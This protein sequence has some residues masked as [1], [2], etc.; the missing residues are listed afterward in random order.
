M[1]AELDNVLS[2]YQGVKNAEKLLFRGTGMGD[3]VEASET[4]G[5]RIDELYKELDRLLAIRSGQEPKLPV[6]EHVKNV[7]RRWKK[8][9]KAEL[10]RELS[11]VVGRYL[12]DV[13]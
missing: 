13:V 9:V 8:E 12:S 7:E 10:K 5:E 4:H 11:D 1:S 6:A 2:L 3:F